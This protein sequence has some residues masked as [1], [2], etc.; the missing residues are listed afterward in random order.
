MAEELPAADMKRVVAMARL[1]L[2]QDAAEA[3]T[4]GWG[5]PPP[6][7]TSLASLAAG[8]LLAETIESALEMRKEAAPARARRARTAAP[9]ARR[10]RTKRAA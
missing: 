3:R 1:A 2:E 5:A 10:P 7:S 8:I 4:R 6:D 9:R